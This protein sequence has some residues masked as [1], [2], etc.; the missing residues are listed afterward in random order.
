MK[1]INII[2]TSASGKSTFSELLATE[3]DYPLIEMDRLFWKANWQE[4]SDE[5]FFSELQ[6]AMAGKTWVLDGNYSRTNFIKWP[7]VDTV[8]W[9]DYSFGR[10][11]FQA[12]KRAISR[13][14]N[15]TELWGKKGNVE[16]FRRTFCSKKS[17]IL[18]TL[19]NYWSNKKRYENL[20]LDPNLSHINFIKITNPKMAN[21]FIQ[22]IKRQQHI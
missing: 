9:I 3:L 17:I 8:I 12:F 14:V 21:T 7:N 15:K 6:Q 5:E 4:S 19:T 13:I 20:F 1:K 11:V 10:T 2:G 16:T 18:W 22:Q